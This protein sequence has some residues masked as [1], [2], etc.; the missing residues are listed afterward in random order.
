MPATFAGFSGE[1]LTEE[2]TF[3]DMGRAR[4]LDDIAGYISY[5][6][7]EKDAR[8]FSQPRVKK[9]MVPMMS[10]EQLKYVDD[11]D[12]FVSR[13]QSEEASLVLQEKLE[14]IVK[15]IEEELK[16]V[17]K[18]HFHRF[19]KKCADFPG[20]PETKCQVVIKKNITALMREVAGYTKNIR[21]QM[22]V[23]RTELA[24][25]KKGNQAKLATIKRKIEENP[26]LYSQYKSSTY[27]ALREKCGSKTQG[28]FMEAVRLLPEVEEIEREI[29]ASRDNIKAM[30]TQLG[31]EMKSAVLSIKQMKEALKR[32]DIAPVEK[33]AIEM[34]IRAAQTDLRKTNKLRKND[35][36]EQVEGEKEKIKELEKEKKTFFKRVRKTLKKIEKTKKSEEKEAKKQAKALRKLETELP[37]DEIKDEEIKNMTIRRE[38]LIDHDLKDLQI[39]MKEKEEDAAKK[40][41]ER[42]EKKAA[43]EEAKEVEREHKRKQKTLKDREK[44][45]AKE[46]ARLEKERAKQESK[47]IKIREKELAKQQ[48][49]NNKTRKQKS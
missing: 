37:E 40:Q 27:S 6:N 26:I 38:A 41:K 14:N 46:R 31:M 24:R 2:G 20:L 11:F 35:L 45:E 15:K 48:K 18:T 43:K 16:T 47:T 9:V 36:Q 8:Q 7:R 5:L 13:S 12:K 44:K 23:V 34:S 21:E 49:A 3:T 22:K 33:T 25:I 42:E 10:E 28:G 4:F 19:Q 1:Y 30:E 39:Q 32:R 29:Q 17:S